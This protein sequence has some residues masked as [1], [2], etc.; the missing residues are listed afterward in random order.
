[1]L[2][3]EGKNSTNPLYFGQCAL[4]SRG[5]SAASM[6]S[7]NR[8]REYDIRERSLT[9]VEQK[10]SKRVESREFPCSPRRVELDSIVILQGEDADATRLIWNG[11]T[12]TDI[13]LALKPGK[14]V[15]YREG[16]NSPVEQFKSA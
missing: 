12:A 5:S 10:V 14:S 7:R 11:Y 9:I 1:M 2:Q 4:N 8:A 13:I 3:A 15:V 6:E 16:E